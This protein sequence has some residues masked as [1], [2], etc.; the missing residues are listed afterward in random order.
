M[1]SFVYM[2][3]PVDIAAKD[4]A[5]KSGCWAKIYSKTNY[6]GDTLTLTGPLSIADM[7]GPYGLDWDD[8]VDS[9][10]LGP[11]ATL[12]VYDNEAYRDQVTQF[13]PGQRVADISKP[14]GFFDE[15]ASIRMTCAK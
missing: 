11:K 12:T 9:I 10:E 6:A 7:D 13:K 3:V 14:L 15:F 8:K 2:V 1:P 4:S 5:M